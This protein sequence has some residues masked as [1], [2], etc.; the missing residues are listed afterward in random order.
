MALIN[1]RNRSSSQVI[2]R[3]PEDGVRRE[4]APGENKKI[5]SEELEKLTFQAGGREILANFLQI[6]N[7]KELDELNI[8]TEPEYFMNEAQVRELIVS[9]SLD[10]FV[11]ALNFAPMGVVDLIKDMA[12]SVP[13]ENTEKK[14]ALREATGFD[15]DAVLKNLEAEKT[16][17]NSAFKTTSSETK[18][19]AKTSSGRKTNPNYKVTTKT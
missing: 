7:E 5:S 18:T 1:V 14:K 19:K 9:G 6:D 10:A 2:Y 3:I 16:A 15:I 13:L 8:P 17:D 4:F 12:V 11:D